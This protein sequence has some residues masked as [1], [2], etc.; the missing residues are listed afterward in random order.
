MKTNTKKLVLSALFLSLAFVLP[1]ITGRIPQIGKS[2]LPMHIPILLCSFICGPYW[3]FTVGLIA[4][5]SRSLLLG[6][7]PPIFPDAVGM[8]FELATYGFMAGTIYKLLK[9]KTWAVY[10][11]LIGSMISG[12]IVWGIV[13]FAM[14]GLFQTKFSFALFLSGGFTKAIPGIVLQI[15][16]IP[17]IVIVLKKTKLYFD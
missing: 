4:P 11:A 13:R 12:R 10:P 8:T 3:G 6:G 9:K 15:V 5:I 16:L 2:L 7:M 17:V 1:F 14:L